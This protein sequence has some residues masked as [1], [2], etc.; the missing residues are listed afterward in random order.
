MATGVACVPASAG[1]TAASEVASATA[2]VAAT[3]A[4]LR[5]GGIRR[6]GERSD[7]QE[8]AGELD[9]ERGPSTAFRTPRLARTKNETTRNSAQDDDPYLTGRQAS[10]VV[11]QAQRR[12][13]LHFNPL[14]RESRGT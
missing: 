3:S 2:H 1:M 5:E 12:I 8:K 4:V 14:F 13:A 11:R 10:R 6:K 7:R 9:S